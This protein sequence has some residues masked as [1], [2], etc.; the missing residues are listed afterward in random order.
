MTTKIKIILGFTLMIALLG[1]VA[2]IGYNGLHSSGTVFTNYARL[3]SFNAGAR[4]VVGLVND[5][6]GAMM[7]YLANHN[8]KHLTNARNILTNTVELVKDLVQLTRMDSTKKDLAEITGNLAR[9][10]SNLDTIELQIDN[11]VAKLEKSIL[12]MERSLNEQFMSISRQMLDANNPQGLL[13]MNVALDALGSLENSL[14]MF[15]QNRGQDATVGDKLSEDLKTLQSATERVTTVVLTQEGKALIATMLK[16]QGEMAAAVREVREYGREMRVSLADYEAM[17]K[18]CYH[19]V[20]R[21]NDVASSQ[22]AQSEQDSD[23]A[24]SGAQY[25]MMLVAIGGLLLGVLVAVYIIFRIVA[26]L[27]DLSSFA[28][29]ISIGDFDYQVKTREKGEIGA[30]VNSMKLIPSV[31]SNMVTDF[32][33]LEKKVEN[34]QIAVTCDASKYSGGFSA[35]IQGTNLVLRRFLSVIDCIPTPVVMLDANLVCQYLNTIGRNLVGSDFKDKTCK[36]MFNRDD[37]GSPTDALRI[38]QESKKPGTSETVAHPSGKDMDISYTAIPMLNDEGK[39]TCFLQLITDVTAIRST[40][41]VI[42]SVTTQASEISNRVAASSEELSAQVEQV[43]RGAEMQRSRVESTATAMTEMNSTV[44]EVARSAGQASEQS[45]ET[46]NKANT[47]SNLVNQVVEAINQVNEVASVLQN[48][49]QG[50]G[51]QAENIG[52]VMN[53]ISDI[54]DQ[55]NLLALNAAIEAARAGEAGRGFAVVADEVRKLA[56]KTMSATQE[57]DSSISAIQH[58]TQTNIDEVGNAV[59]SIADANE[60]A[61]NSRLALNEIVELAT[62]NSEVVSSIATAA[63][64]QSATSEEINKAI[65]EI[66]TV[67]G[68]TTEGMIQASAAVQELAHMAQELN[69]VMGELPDE[70]RAA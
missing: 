31:L 6:D 54:A 70:K 51:T 65:E 55:T 17:N 20:L 49:M 23:K 28:E 53:M 68:E 33:E 52:G 9:M 61:N 5:A 10:L 39:A 50:L 58:S 59:K 34:G 60:L 42:Q 63:E 44:L 32:K 8:E 30:M 69:R 18:A 41:R 46:K 4:S 1:V 3:T 64:E 56:E 67:V 15:M 25:M 43:S 11:L 22:M 12:P 24:I 35:L 26:M 57:V 21:L 13:A 16:T 62:S 14:G 38:A 66:N 37:D 36:Q 45:E 47:G 27:R 40:Q 2:L 7:R 29:A 48:N 19:A